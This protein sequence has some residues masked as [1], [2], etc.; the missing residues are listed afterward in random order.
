MSP[1]NPVLPGFFPDPS[2]CR[3]G[4]RYY[5]A[6]STFEYF[7]GLPL[8]VSDDLQT[9][10]PIGAAIDRADAMDFSAMADSKG[11]YAPTIRHHD[12][13]F[14]MVCTLVGDGPE[15]GFIVTATDPAGPWSDPV[16]V[17]RADGFDPSLFFAGKVYWCA[18]RIVRPGDYFGQTEIW[19]RELDL[20]RAEFAGEETVIWQSALRDATWS[21][22]PH[23]F[24][25]NGWFYLLT[26][27]AGT[28]RD[29]AVVIGRSRSITGPYENCPR[30]PLLTHRQ[31]GRA[32]PVQNVGHADFVQRADGSW[33]AV[34]LAVRT[35]DDRHVLGRET[36]VADVTWED[37][38][39]V[40]N[41]GYGALRDVGDRVCSEHLEPAR[42]ADA[43]TVRGPADFAKERADGVVLRSTGSRVTGAGHPAALLYRLRNHNAEITVTFG[44]VDDGAAA[45]LLLRQSSDFSL[46]LQLADGHA[47][48]IRREAGI[49]TVLQSWPAAAPLTVGAELRADGVRFRTGGR[50]SETTTTEVLSS[51]VAGGFV[52]TVWGPYVEGETGRAA[53]VTATDYRSAAE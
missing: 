22:A 28:F 29:H 37:D 16:W 51:E 53:L 11:L 6:N 48:V 52:G 30:N 25:R 4:D 26:A 2:V 49:D 38:W 34:V 36:F 5:L 40:I 17:P 27:K 33:S 41:P 15:S 39:P 23:L 42:I 46:R 47:Q 8:H 44:D 21:E 24:E 14:Y 12:G 19:I 10:T 32:F 43:L 13:V 20:E 50:W 7:P 35:V 45:G 1:V 18:A 31:F 9:W 3:A